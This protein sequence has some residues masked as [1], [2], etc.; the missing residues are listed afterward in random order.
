MKG[1]TL[2]KLQWW[3]AN[4][5]IYIIF[6]V[7]HGDNLYFYITFDYIFVDQDTLIKFRFRGIIKAR[8]GI[9]SIQNLTVIYYKFNYIF[10][11]YTNIKRW[12][13]V[14]I[15]KKT[16]EIFLDLIKK[17]KFVHLYANLFEVIQAW[18]SNEFVI[19]YLFIFLN[20]ENIETNKLID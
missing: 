9:T 3:P 13:I 2:C 15:F 8:G 7:W 10:K 20:R 1:N 12:F 19:F 5:Y 16:N 6:G 11:R 17:T 14:L 18:E 4:I